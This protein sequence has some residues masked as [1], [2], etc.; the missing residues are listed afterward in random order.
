[1][2]WGGGDEQAKSAFRLNWLSVE[3]DPNSAKHQGP[4]YPTIKPVNLS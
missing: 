3:L 4:T 1:M 2:R